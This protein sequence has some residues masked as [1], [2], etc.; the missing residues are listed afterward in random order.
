MEATATIFDPA[1][2]EICRIEV[3]TYIPIGGFGI[4]SRSSSKITK[5]INDAIIT[6]LIEDVIAY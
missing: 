5:T 4:I 2:K 3:Q 6:H 1:D